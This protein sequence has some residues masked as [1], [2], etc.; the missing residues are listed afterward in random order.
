MSD[1]DP[2]RVV[3]QGAAVTMANRPGD[4][5][6]QIP[7]DRPGIVILI[8]GVND[9][10]GW[11]E[12]VEKG[13]CT[14]VN[15]RL[16]RGDLNAGRYGMDYHAAA[17]KKQPKID[18]RKYLE[19]PETFLYKRSEAD[20]THSFV[21]PFY[22]GYRAAS[23]E[24]AKINDA[25]NVKSRQA[26]ANGNLMT[27]G[28]YQDKHGNRLDKHFA[29]G[30]GFFANAT[31]NIPDM[32]H[33][34]FEAPGLGKFVTSTNLSGNYTYIA[35]APERRYYV[36]AA[37]RLASLIS[38]IRSIEPSGA[39]KADGYDPAHDTITVVGHS[40][41][42]IITLLAQALLAQRGK[43]CIDCLIMVDSP[44]G[45][46]STEQS[47]QTGRAKLKTFVDIVNELTKQPYSVPQLAELLATSDKAGGRTGKDWSPAQGKRKDKQGNEVTFKERD[48]RGKVYLYFCPEDTVV[49]L[50]NM[51]GIG[52]FG[53]PD[54]VPSETYYRDPNRTRPQH[55]GE[56]L[57]AMT[58]LQN[59]RF[60]QRMWTRMERDHSGDGK[61]RKVMVG[62]PPARVPIRQQNERLSVGPV[63]D[64]TPWGTAIVSGKNAATLDAHV[65]N[66][67]RYV[68]GEALTPP[69]EPELYGGEAIKGGPRPGHEDVA[70]K[71]VPDVVEQ[72]VALG[73]QYASFNWID[74][75]TTMNP[76]AD[77]DTYKASYNA[78]KPIEQQ[79][80]NW[81][82][83]PKKVLGVSVPG[84]LIVQREQTPQEARETMEKD[85]SSWEDNNYHGAILR[86]SENHRWVT[87]MDIAIG[88]AVSIDDKD[89]RDLLT[90]MAD[91]KLDAGAHAQLAR[92]P[93]YGKLKAIDQK[94]V[95]L[96][97]ASA[98]YYTAGTFPAE[99]VVPLK[100]M[101]PLV[102]S[103]TIVEQKNPPALPP[104]P[105]I[106][107]SAF[108]GMPR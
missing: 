69:H 106:D 22:W 58:D 85:K 51:H 99:S 68:N 16:S 77:L 27:R 38:T 65:H 105:P 31:N 26:D 5:H 91:W 86:S 84:V 33:T 28:Q 63:T 12:T 96:I 23:K 100:T 80:Q 98:V 66:D 13:L 67:I 53:V 97:D 60:F 108:S 87:A 6:V 25:G 101:P 95:D 24:I 74:V 70:G 46:Y 19:D 57:P 20:S 9:P 34:H 15:E 71:L 49:A 18:E 17:Q 54:A 73:N 78:S 35:D 10:G 55:Y 7:A 11:Y 8:H 14:G 36:L 92:N 56:N 89:W 107:W 61:F 62:L 72:N 82:L 75:D 103:E 42:T 52:T 37:E 90:G 47:Q 2:D 79:S 88:Q 102:T 64:G 104:A 3:V 93:N 48:N 94:A 41:G 59:K 4:R 45:L 32:Y 21:I 44:Y 83:V 76:F 40:Q 30:G 81:R 39:A 29:K 50:S 1:N 43:R